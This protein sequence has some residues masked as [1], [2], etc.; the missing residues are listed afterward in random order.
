M[1]I[2]HDQNFKELISTN[3]VEGDEQRFQSEIDKMN[4]IQKEEIMQITTSWEEKGMEKERR[5]LALKMLQE[6]ATLQFVE[7]VTGLTV[8]QLQQLQSQAGH[9]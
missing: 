8:E 3:L 9:N 1:T 4:P 7:K 2:G 6:G 5:S